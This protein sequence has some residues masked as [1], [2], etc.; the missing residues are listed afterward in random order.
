MRP[1]KESSNG[2][3]VDLDCDSPAGSDEAVSPAEDEGEALLE[4][5]VSTTVVIK[6]SKTKRGRFY[7]FHKEMK[8]PKWI[9]TKQCDM[10][11]G[12]SLLGWD[13]AHDGA[14]E[15]IYP[16]TEGNIDSNEL[17]PY[18]MTVGSLVHW[19]NKALRLL[20]F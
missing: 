2:T 15:Y 19:P 16:V 9:N 20:L 3:H 18:C 5:Y 11:D 4:P 12:V 8:M 6:E 13:I 14:E 7:A 17:S 1:A 10:P